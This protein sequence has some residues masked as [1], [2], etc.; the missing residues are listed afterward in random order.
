MTSETWAELDHQNI[1]RTQRW[2]SLSGA[3]QKTEREGMEGW[4]FP[5][6]FSDSF[7]TSSSFT[8]YSVASRKSFLSTKSE[9]VYFCIEIFLC[10]CFFF[11]FRVFVFL[12]SR[13]QPASRPMSVRVSTNPRHFPCVSIFS[14]RSP[15]NCDYHARSAPAVLFPVSHHC[16]LKRFPPSPESTRLFILVDKDQLKMSF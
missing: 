8:L 3:G 4:T 15:W 16:P 9:I 12:A 11:S 1:R 14:R 7:N 5:L 2:A 10:I 6:V 13:V